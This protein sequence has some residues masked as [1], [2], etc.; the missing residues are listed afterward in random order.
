[1][2]ISDWLK[3]VPRPSNEFSFSVT[4]LEE[5]S[6]VPAPKDLA[7]VLRDSYFEKEFLI[8]VAERY[9][10]EKVQDKLLKARAGTISTVKKGDF[11]EA[12]TAEYL[13]R[14]ECF[15]IPVMKLRY[16]ISANQTLPGTDCLALKV[17][18][19]KLVEVGYVESK[20]RA[21]V[22]LS[23]AIDGVK[24]LA[25]DAAKDVPEILV[26]VASQLRE[27]NNALYALFETYLFDRN[28]D[29]DA[30]ILM[31]LHESTKWN[32]LVLVNL[33]DEQL[34][35]EPLQVYVAKISDLNRLADDTFSALGAGEIEDRG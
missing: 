31:I 18:G 6:S 8:E 33:E 22:D 29:L 21:S 24:Q 32:E 5:T 3:P 14:V 35:L 27:S 2:D 4:D 10:F 19:G 30:Y 26:F 9:G 15:Q 25:K 20:Y 17:S 7:E 11:G 13:T 34:E 23:V 1:M 16:K 28:S 12:I